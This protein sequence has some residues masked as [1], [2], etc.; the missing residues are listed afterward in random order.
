[1]PGKTKY[2]IEEAGYINSEKSNV[3]AEAKAILRGLQTLKTEIDAA[4]LPTG[5]RLAI[6]AIT[7]CCSNLESMNKDRPLKLRTSRKYV[8]VLEEIKAACD[9]LMG[10]ELDVT[11]EIYWCPRNAMPQLSDADALAGYARTT[12]KRVWNVNSGRFKDRTCEYKTSEGLLVEA[13]WLR[14]IR[15]RKTATGKVVEEEMDD[16]LET[17]SRQYKKQTVRIEEPQAASSNNEPQEDEDTEDRLP[18]NG[19]Y[20]GGRRWYH[21]MAL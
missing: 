15:R 4:E 8:A 1:M 14:R 7:D 6:I 5:T 18:E 10:L 9:I 12:R 11:V 17:A 16:S 2:T 21:C 3:P 13:K 20:L 19:D